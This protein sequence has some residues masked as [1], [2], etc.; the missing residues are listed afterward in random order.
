M[1][2]LL[3]DLS[4]FSTVLPCLV[5]TILLRYFRKRRDLLLLWLLFLFAAA[6]DVSMDILAR[7]KTPN[8]L[9]FQVYCLLEYVLV[10]NIL[11]KWHPDEKAGKWMRAAIPIY[12][13]A[14]VVI[15][16]AGL[17]GLQTDSHN[18]ITRPIA[19]LIMIVSTFDA[20][21]A[22]WNS[23][24][25]NF[26]RDYR[27]WC[28]IALAIYYSSSVVFISFTYMKNRELLLGIVYLHAAINILHNILFTIGIVR[29]ASQG[30]VL[31]TSAAKQN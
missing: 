2:D 16:A 28:M 1:L 10:L 24:P 21:H 20:L 7:S 14:Y 5:S 15:K 13:A 29:A 8:L 18:F 17:E 31:M 30:T 19:L 22:L 9:I 26:S 11:S 25:T 23:A 4:V 3:V 12:V 6:T 27:F